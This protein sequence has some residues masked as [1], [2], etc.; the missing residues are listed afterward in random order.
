MEK[1]YRDKYNAGYGLTETSPVVAIN[2]L[3]EPY[4]GFIG[5]PVQSTKIR[6]IDDNRKILGITNPVNFAAFK[7]PSYVWILE[8]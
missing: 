3:D 7:A 2:K 1:S 6:I 5:L 8:T 4:N